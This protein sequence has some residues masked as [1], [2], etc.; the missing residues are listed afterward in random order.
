MTALKTL[1]ARSDDDGVTVTF[2]GSN[3]ER[4]VAARKARIVA[5]GRKLLFAYAAVTGENAEGVRVGGD[6][7]Q[8]GPV[9]TYR[10]IF[11][12]GPPL[13]GRE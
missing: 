8:A 1:E 10:Y 11:R 12:G 5:N 13:G 2:Y 3:G 7:V 4:A 9:A 6:P